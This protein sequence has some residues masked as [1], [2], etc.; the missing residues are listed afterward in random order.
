MSLQCSGCGKKLSAPE[1][2]AG[3]TVKCPACKA[4]VTIPAAVS[5]LPAMRSDSTDDLLSK[6]LFDLAPEEPPAARPSSAP[7]PSVAPQPS[8]VP[9]RAAPAKVAP[10]FWEMGGA[11]AATRTKIMVGVAVV[12]LGVLWGVWRIWHAGGEHPSRP[13]A[14]A[15]AVSAARTGAVSA[16][17]TGAVSAA[18]TTASLEVK[19]T[20]DVAHTPPPVGPRQIALGVEAFSVALAVPSGSPGRQNTLWIYKPKGRHGPH[21]LGCVFMAPAG[22]PIFAGNTL[23]EGDRKE[24]RPYAE[25][26][27]V[28]VALELDGPCDTEHLTESGAKASFAAFSAAMGGLVNG[29]NAV[30]YVLATMP[31]VDPGRLY[32]AGHSS[33]ATFA[34]LFAEHESRIKG[35]IACAPVSDFS[36]TILGQSVATTLQA[37]P[38]LARLSP[39][40]YAK[41]LTCPLFVFHAEDDRVVPISTSRNFLDKVRQTNSK[42]VFSSVP[43]GDHYESMINEGIPRALRWLAELPVE[44]AANKARPSG[45]PVATGATPPVGPAVGPSTPAGSKPEGDHAG[46]PPKASSPPGLT[47]SLP[48]Q[49]AP[50]V[51]PAVGPPKRAREPHTETKFSGY[52]VKTYAQWLG[53]DRRVADGMRWFAAGKR[54]VLALRWGVGVYAEAHPTSVDIPSPMVLFPLA[55]STGPDLVA[56]LARRADGDK[57]A[58]WPEPSNSQ[59]NKVPMF[60]AETEADL[61]KAGAQQQVDAIVAIVTSGQPTFTGGQVHISIEI[62]LI[63]VIGGTTLWKLPRTNQRIAQP[64]KV[65][66]ATA[67]VVNNVI[68]KLDTLA[69]LREMPDISEPVAAA[70]VEKLRRGDL[71]AAARLRAVAEIRYYELKKLISAADA[72]AAYKELISDE[73]ARSMASGAADDRA[74][75]LKEW[76]RGQ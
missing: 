65:D 42:T 49:H 30:D 41:Q 61:I 51:C 60:F 54:P 24:H 22:A 28:V 32:V 43:T 57:D 21:S 35:C 31:E 56:A 7:R 71:S 68:K 34:L 64:G 15:G 4:A 55:G 36:A 69:K 39:Q 12:I 59:L 52:M 6:R 26:G 44:R 11:P 8:A 18:G 62:R 1:K 66:S 5:E 16:A 73:F 37:L 63:D 47:S 27:Y 20:V 33:A 74:E 72:R 48:L 45:Q 46:L 2:L 70:R 3:K 58:G 75:A 67:A 13:S 50:P 10:R 23:G 14:G 17:G 76:A 53:D 19:S 9:R 29:A 25:A 38:G 40:N